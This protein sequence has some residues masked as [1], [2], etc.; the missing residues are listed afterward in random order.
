M[1]INYNSEWQE[2]A[3][4][5]ANPATG[6]WKIYFKADGLYLLEDNGTEHGPFSAGSVGSA[7]GS[8]GVEA[9]SIW[10]STTAG[11]AA[12]T[13]S[14]YTTNDQDLYGLAFD[15]TT[16]EH[17][18][19]SVLMPGDWDAGTLTFEA[20]WTAAAGTGNVI[21]ALQGV[22]YANSDPI[23]AAWGTAQTVT[24]T[25][26]TTVD[27]HYSPV[28]SAITL[29]GT[30][31]AGRLVQFRVYRVAAD[32]GDTLNADAVLLGVRIIYSKG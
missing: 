2:Q 19:F 1:A 30:P 29:A 28:S 12:A 16:Q 21:W 26:L 25:L 7:T 22:C 3:S 23:D 10:P 11:S 31:A 13:K 4:A 27:V 18:Q 9:F 5:P 6:N 32:G 24:D 14:E 8:I 20:T 15:Q 17:A